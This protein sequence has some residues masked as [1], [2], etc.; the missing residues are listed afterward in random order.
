MAG[1]ALYSGSTGV[2]EQLNTTR[3]WYYWIGGTGSK[4]GTLTL[5]ISDSPTGNPVLA[6][7]DIALSALVSV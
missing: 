1:S 7:C 2:W 3:S 6:T 4:S 5:E